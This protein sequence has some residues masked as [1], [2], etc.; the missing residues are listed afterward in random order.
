MAD[1][2]VIREEKYLAYLTGDYT[3]GLQKPITRTEKYLY[4]LCLK[5]I[6][7]GISPEEIKNAVNEYLEKNPVKPGA[8]TEQAQ[9]IEQNK[10]DVASLKENVKYLSDSYVTPEMFGAVGDGLTDDTSALV[11]AFNSYLPVNLCGLTY[12]TDSDTE[13]NV[14]SDF[15][16]GTIIADSSANERSIIF[17]VKEDGVNIENITIKSVRDNVDIPQKNHTRITTL[18]SNRVGIFCEATTF[19]KKLVCESLETDVM[20]NTSDNTGQIDSIAIDGWKSTNGSNTSLFFRCKNI[21][22]SNADVTAAAELG[23]GDHFVYVSS[24]CDSLIIR[25]SVFIAPDKNFGS[26]FKCTEESYITDEAALK[27]VWIINTKTVSRTFLALSW[28]TNAN[29]SNCNLSFPFGDKDTEALISKN[30]DADNYF[31][32]GSVN[33]SNCFITGCRQLAIANKGTDDLNDCTITFNNCI[34]DVNWINRNVLSKWVSLVIDSCKFTVDLITNTSLFIKSKTY[35][36]NSVIKTNNSIFIRFDSHD[37]IANAD[38]LICLTSNI[39]EGLDVTYATS[40]ERNIILQ[41]N[42][43]TLSNAVA[44]TWKT[45]WKLLNGNYINGKLIT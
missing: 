38:Y 32:K 2:P 42:V 6:G 41:N 24:Y 43:F 7:G 5:G 45:N 15:Y 19:I 21:C 44:S 33:V 13:I 10:T 29:V 25:D 31:I 22:I 3:G 35:I 1:K 37:E 23:S 4:E 9:Q 27:N 20:S 40:E 34:G 14:Y 30:K 36:K 18:G 17:R 12:H 16:N 28:S 8:T 39:I 11:N 26:I